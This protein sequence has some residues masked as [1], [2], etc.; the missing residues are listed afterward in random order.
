RRLLQLATRLALEEIVHAAVDE[1]IAA[2]D[3]DDLVAG[4][5]RLRPH[6]AALARPMHDPVRN[7]A[8]GDQCANLERRRL[9]QPA[10][11]RG[12]PAAMKLREFARFGDQ[13]ARRHGQ[14][15]FAVGR[16]DAERIS[17]RASV[18][19]HANRK[20]LRAVLDQNSRWFGGPPIEERA[21]GHVVKSGEEESTRNLPHLPPWESLGA[22]TN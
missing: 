18:P 15:G 22:K 20:D 11:A 21:S 4:V 5:A 1:I 19:P 16:M 7:A 13:A 3:A 6:R 2:G 12:D 10:E 8:Q 14:D 17:A 9:R